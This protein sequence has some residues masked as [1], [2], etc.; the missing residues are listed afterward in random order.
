MAVE[1]KKGGSQGPPWTRF[2]FA[3][4]TLPTSS[5]RSVVLP[6]MV[7][8]HLLLQ[9]RSWTSAAAPDGTRLL[10]GQ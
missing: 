4:L 10:I 2:I 6:L 7:N 1:E 8:R 3:F 5:H 9:R